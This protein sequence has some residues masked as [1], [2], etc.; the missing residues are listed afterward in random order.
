M[1]ILL[2]ALATIP[3]AERHILSYPK[4]MRPS[5]LAR[6]TGVA[7]TVKQHGGI[8]V[9]TCIYVSNLSPSESMFVSGIVLNLNG[10]SEG[11]TMREEAKDLEEE[12]KRS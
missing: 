7:F 6:P 11:F 2:D 3:S 9:R 12:P 5:D 10:V 8:T 1:F 4:H